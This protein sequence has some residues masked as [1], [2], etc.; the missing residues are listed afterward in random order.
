MGI[1]LS[2]SQ[3]NAYL[4]IHHYLLL[5]AIYMYVWY[6]Y[7]YM[8]ICIGMHNNICSILTAIIPVYVLYVCISNL[9]ARAFSQASVNEFINLLS[10]VALYT[11][12]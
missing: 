11:F 1:D 6:Y 8:N 9:H 4:Y 2:E 10:V 3:L 7:Y 5:C 12:D